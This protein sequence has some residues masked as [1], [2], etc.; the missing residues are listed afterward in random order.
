[1]ILPNGNDVKGI[2]LWV[3]QDIND[4][5]NYGI[6]IS[7]DGNGSNGIITTLPTT[8]V[9]SGEKIL[10]TTDVQAYSDY[11]GNCF[12]NYDEI[13]NIPANSGFDFD[14]ND[15]ISL[16][17]LDIPILMEMALHGTTA[18]HGHTKTK[19]KEVLILVVVLGCLV[20]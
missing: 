11:F 17:D 14:G 4:I 8:N 18:I 2:E 9:S 16:K 20:M 12:Q 13:I 3:N 5:S 19:I 10:I 7:H 6:E 15:A 1:M